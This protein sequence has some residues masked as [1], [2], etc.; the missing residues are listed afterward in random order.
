MVCFD[1]AQHWLKLTL[2]KLAN[3]IKVL[4]WYTEPAEVQA[5]RLSS[6]N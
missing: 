3:L 4:E 6:V 5:K 2:R 1:N